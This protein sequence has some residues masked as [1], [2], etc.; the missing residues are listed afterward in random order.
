MRRRAM[1]WCIG[2]VAIVGL[3]LGVGLVAPV[4]SVEIDDTSTP[5]I[6]QAHLPPGVEPTSQS[7]ECAS[8]GCWLRLQFDSERLP[9]AAGDDLLQMHGNCETVALFDRRQVCASVEIEDSILIVDLSF[10]RP[11]RL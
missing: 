1:W 9:T 10:K 3:A 5:T 11:L 6:S 8:G 4:V 7:I 2:A